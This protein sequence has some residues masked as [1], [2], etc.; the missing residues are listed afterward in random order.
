MVQWRLRNGYTHTHTHT[1]T[2]QDLAARNVLVSENET[3]KVADFGLL[4]EVPKDDSFYHMQ[5]NVPC[6]VRWMPPESISDRNFSAASDVWSFGVLLWEIF[7][8]TKT[9]YEKLGNIEVASKVCVGM[10][11]YAVCVVCMGVVLYAM[12]VWVDVVLYAVCVGGCGCDAVCVWVWC[13]T[14][15][16]WVDVGVMLCVWVDVGV[17]LCVC[18]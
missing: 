14:L 10:V 8:P 11:L 1:H 17:M 18:V 5:T 3:C 6:P 13:C 7:N 4:R 2:L 15:C 16:G 12:C 9:P